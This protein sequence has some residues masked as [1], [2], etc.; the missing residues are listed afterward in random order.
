MVVA[1]AAVAAEVVA[2]RAGPERV[3]E[4]AEG[5]ACGRV[6]WGC[7]AAA[8][9]GSGCRWVAPVLV[10]SPSRVSRAPC[11]SPANHAPGRGPSRAR[12]LRGGRGRRVRARKKSCS[13][14]SVRWRPVP[15][16]APGLSLGPD[17]GCGRAGRPRRRLLH[18]TELRS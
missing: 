18:G 10:L 12:P 7:T 11:P 13:R 14:P 17:P 9:T 3:V 16:A 2:A 1:A 6:G 4:V 15:R 8:W 5:R